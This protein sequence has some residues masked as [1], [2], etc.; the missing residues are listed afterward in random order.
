MGFIAAFCTTASF[1][2]QA[3]KVYRTKRTSDISLGMFVLMSLGV[4]FWDAYG[5]LINSLPVIVANTVTLLLSAY[6]LLMKLKLERKKL[7][8]N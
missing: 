8:N 5:F 3:I 2:P 4:A 1:I 6:I 7:V